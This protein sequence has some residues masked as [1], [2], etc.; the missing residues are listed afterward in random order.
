LKTDRLCSVV[1]GTVDFDQFRTYVKDFSTRPPAPHAFRTAHARVCEAASWYLTLSFHKAS[2]IFVAENAVTRLFISHSSA[3]D[4][5]AVAIRDWLAREGWNDVFLD[6]DPER[7]IKAGERWERALNE[8]ASR[9][10]A[11]LFLISRAWHQSRWCLRE[12][13]LARR[14]NKRLLGAVVE[15]LPLSDLPEDLIGQ[16]Q[17]VDL[18]SVPVARS[19]RDCFPTFSGLLA[20]AA[21]FRR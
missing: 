10:E 7:G 19:S 2:R 5:E 21:S 11:V 8:A 13:N 14:L 6:L 17:V 12:F 1:D 9:C 15:E 3:N 18:A 16:W 20:D 4:A